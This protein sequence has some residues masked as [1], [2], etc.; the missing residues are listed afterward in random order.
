[1]LDTATQG[2][3][4]GTAWEG[5]LFNGDWIAAPRV[6]DVI[7]PATGGALTRTGIGGAAE[8]AT[9]AKVA[10][11]AQAA[12]FA[13][14]ER[15]RE[16]IL[17]KAADL[18]ETHA[19]ELSLWIARETGAIIP[20]GQHE[21]REA[22]EICRAA[23]A[24]LHHI[25]SQVLPSTP[26]RLSVARRVPLGV[27]GV[28]SPFNF[29]LILGLRAVAPALAI[30]NGVVL[31]PDPQTVVSG[32]VIIARIFE[33]AGL[34]KGLLH[35]V[36]GYVEA[37][38][39]LCTDPN[40]Q[41][42]AFTGSTAAGRKVGETCGRNLK[43]VSLELGGKNSV[44][45]LGDA[46]L[47]SA[48]SNVAFGAWF[49]QGQICMASGRI[50]VERSLVPAL[51]A[52]LVEK[53]NHLPVG[54]PASGQVA[55]GPLINQRQLDRVHKLVT[56]TVAAGAKL[57]AGGTYEKLFYKPTVLENVRPGMPCF[58][59]EIFGP[60]VNIV[61]F[62]TDEEAVKLANDTEYGLSAGV[63]GK[64]IGRA[65]KIARQLKTGLIH[66]NDQSVA[67]DVANPFGG[68]GASGNGTAVGGPASWE[69]FSMWQWMTV[70]AD[71]PMK[72]F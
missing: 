26:E 30:G 42:V 44:I 61:P 71:A 31:K 64:D 3:F 66:I 14:H 8:V 1:M 37:G 72:P 10:T 45:I 41:M 57:A 54:D 4:L 23:A 46:D 13:T 12:W 53:A 49:H 56:E 24:L 16:A 39:A 63:I 67:D 32:G 2:S 29:P 60:V 20:K 33:M 5:K 48:A 7:E 65:M 9:A 21:V 34:P 59:E 68:R 52:A 62:D 47:A 15:T 28:I 40:I 69:E 6:V 38:E 27:V 35:M 50:L 11:E 55:L 19:E 18:F 43:K 17:L 70:Q 58:D 36:P 25:P 51:T 22:V